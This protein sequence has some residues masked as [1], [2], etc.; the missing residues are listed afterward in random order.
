MDG[1]PGSGP[2]RSFTRRRLTRSSPPPGRSLADALLGSPTTVALTGRHR[3]RSPSTCRLWRIR[4]DGFRTADTASRP[5]RATPGRAWEPRRG[6]TGETVVPDLLPDGS[7]L[8]VAL[9]PSSSGYGG[10]ITRPGRHRPRDVRLAGGARARSPGDAHSD[11][12]Q[13]LRP[14][15]RSSFATICSEATCSLDFERSPS[16]SARRAIVSSTTTATHPRR[17]DP[18]ARVIFDLTA[19][20]L[21][22]TWPRCRD[23]RRPLD[24]DERPGRDRRTSHALPCLRT[25]ST[26][27]RSGR[28]SRAARGTRPTGCGTRL[29]QMG[30]LASLRERFPDRWRPGER[31]ASPTGSPG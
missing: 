31:T 24:P 22:S 1:T 10:A 15:P 21:T 13:F 5:T 14:T 26:L 3:P 9:D 23:S 2:P 12:E 8:T 18:R 30:E 7:P 27:I 29:H 20:L 4:G 6:D 28:R 25:V 11:A 19:A 17:R 16:M